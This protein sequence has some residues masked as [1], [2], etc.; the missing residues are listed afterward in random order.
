MSLIGRSLRSLRSPFTSP[1][2]S[3]FSWGGS[4]GFSLATPISHETALTFSAVYAAVSLISE[5]VMTLPIGVYKD[6]PPNL[7]FSGKSPDW[8]ERPNPES[9]WPQFVQQTVTSLLLDGNAFWGLVRSGE[10]LELW[11]LD[12]R[13]VSV[14][15]DPTTN[16]LTYRWGGETLSQQQCV[17]IPGLMLPGSIRGLSPVECA[18]QTIDLGLGAET[19]GNAFY[20]NGATVSA[21]LEAQPG[22]T[23]PEAKEM[24]EIFTAKHGGAANAQGVAILSGATYKSMS[25]TQEQAQFLQT[26]SFQVSEV[27]RWFRVPPHM[28][29]DVEK[30]S[31]WGT[32]IEQQQT[33]FV[34][35]T[36]LPWL[37]RIEAALTR[38][39]QY[40][41]PLNLARFTVNGLMR[42]DS[43]ARASFYDSMVRNGAF[44]P[45]D[46]RRLENQNPYKG[47]DARYMQT[48]YAPIGEDG[49]LVVPS[50]DPGQAPVALP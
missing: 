14:Q 9:T 40:G 23:Q 15:R 41:D 19:F 20:H 7:R 21:V 34:T 12:P 17:H 48:S 25:M 6:Y 44:S 35:H 50:T 22:M 31:S 27:A 42:G 37:V 28:I 36:L 24:W 45:N 39:V 38:L 2:D 4:P 47:G 33:M 49:S 8:M 43:A 26:R 11:P 30:D 18:R 3:G 29:A 46:I 32:G 13:V 5:T 16:A 1:F 10:Y